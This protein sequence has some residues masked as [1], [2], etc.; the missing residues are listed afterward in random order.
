MCESEVF[1]ESPSRSRSAEWQYCPDRLG[2]FARRRYVRWAIA[3]SRTRH[4]LTA[5]VRS[6]YAHMRLPVFDDAASATVVRWSFVMLCKS[7]R[8]HFLAEV[9]F[10]CL[11]DDDDANR[12][13]KGYFHTHPIHVS[14][15]Y[16]PQLVD[17][18]AIITKLNNAVD[19]FTCRGILLLLFLLLFGS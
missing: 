15:A 3:T 8:V 14:A 7:M 5:L 12:R 11:T 2:Y 10:V 9:D 13:M 16:K 4:G 17:F 18:S 19:Q 6:L 1:E